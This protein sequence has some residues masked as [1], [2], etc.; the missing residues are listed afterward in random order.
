MSKPG[1][2]EPHHDWLGYLFAFGA[3][4][5]YGTSGVLIKSG[6]AAYGSP[7]TA[8]TIATATGLL[9]LSPLALASWRSQ[10]QGWRPERRAL[11]FILASGLCAITGFSSN[12]LALSQLPVTVVAPISSAYPLVTVTLVLI[13]LRRHEVVSWRTILGAALIVTGIIIVALNRH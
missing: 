13:F 9:V 2:A 1:G 7:F 5:A 10:G 8:I 11:L 4:T 3:A 12:T 6:L